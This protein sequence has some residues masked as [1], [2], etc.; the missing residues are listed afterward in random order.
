MA[1]MFFLNKL[2]LLNDFF[3]Q[4]NYFYVAETMLN[5]FAE[6][7]GATNYSFARTKFT[8]AVEDLQVILKF[9]LVF[10]DYDAFKKIEELTDESP[11]KLINKP[12]IA[13]SITSNMSQGIGAKVDLFFKSPSAGESVARARE[14]AYQ[15]MI[16]LRFIDLDK[17][18]IN[19]GKLTGKSQYPGNLKAKQKL[20][21]VCEDIF[22]AFVFL[23]DLRKFLIVNDKPMPDLISVDNKLVDKVVEA[24]T[25]VVVTLTELRAS[26]DILKTNLQ[27]SSYSMVM[28]E[29][30]THCGYLRKAHTISAEVPEYMRHLSAKFP[31]IKIMYVAC[32]K[33]NKDNHFNLIRELNEVYEAQLKFITDFPSMRDKFAGKDELDKQRNKNMARFNAA[34]GQ[35]LAKFTA[36]LKVFDQSL[37]ISF[38]VENSNPTAEEQACELAIVNA[39]LTEA[40]MLERG[41]CK[42]ILVNQDQVVL[43]HGEIAFLIITSQEYLKNVSKAFKR[44]K[45]VSKEDIDQALKQTN[46]SRV[47][48]Q[49]SYQNALSIMRGNTFSFEKNRGFIQIKNVIMQEIVLAILRITNQVFEVK[50]QDYVSIKITLKRIATVNKRIA[51]INEKLSG[52]SDSLAELMSVGFTLF[53]RYHKLSGALRAAGTFSDKL[54]PTYPEMSPTLLDKTQELAEVLEDANQCMTACPQAN[55]SNLFS[56]LVKS[57]AEIH[58]KVNR[59]HRLVDDIKALAPKMNTINIRIESINIKYASNPHRFLTSPS[60]TPSIS[61]PEEVDEKRLSLI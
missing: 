3:L 59:I 30:D 6:I 38:K 11:F 60:T 52:F 32:D 8:I 57:L 28:P 54:K 26:V 12:L 7:A 19:T 56:E 46:K 40:D 53:E 23:N 14:R 5:C 37:P 39:V 25:A 27:D 61:I 49:E 9:V 18:K 33:L 44:I 36:A 31:D 17:F 58:V 2:K 35:A 51:I 55:D 1:L 24:K 50:Q 45:I 15:M 13:E 48:L 41:D 4:D 16:I 43:A 10:L 34:F 20:A 47:M 22:Y 42:V 21:K 29:Y